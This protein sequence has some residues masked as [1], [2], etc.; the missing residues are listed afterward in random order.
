[1]R[2]RK[3]ATAFGVI[4]WCAFAPAQP[5]PVDLMTAMDHG[6]FVS[7]TLTDDPLST[8]GIFV[9][10]GIA[11]R[12]APDAVL[13]F[14]TDLLR[15]AR[16]WTG[17]FLKW[18]PA[19]HGLQEWP[20]PDGFSHHTTGPRPGWSRNKNFTDP[21]SRPYGPVPATV[22][23]Y[24]GLYLH[25]D[26]VVFSY[27]IGA[28]QVLDAPG[29]E[30]LENR[31]V[32]TRTFNVDASVESLSLL[33]SD[34]PDGPAST[35]ETRRQTPANGQAVIRSGEATRRIGFRGLP[36][37]A[38]WRREH[39]QLILDLPP[40]KEPLRFEVALGPI[41]NGN[42]DYLTAYLA[43]TG[44]VADLAP[45]RQPGPPRW[46]EI[47]TQAV[48]GQDNASFAVD[49]LTLPEDNPWRSYL[50]PSGLDFLP[51]GRA[52][53]ASLSG[54]V[55][56]VDGIGETLGTLRWKR[57]ATGLNQPL[58]VR[59]V[60][61]KIY[62]TGRDQITRL[63]DSNGDGTADYYENFNNDVMAAT[64][65]HAFTLNLETDSK[66]NFYFAKATPWPPV[67]K[68]VKAEITPHHG[69]LFRLSPDG[70]K[71][72]VVADGLRNPNGMTIGPG[73][74]IVYSDNEGNWV[75]TSKVHRIRL[76]AFHGFIPSSHS[77]PAPRDFEKP[78]AWIPHFVDNSPAQPIFIA[79]P[80]WPEELQGQLLLA[81][82]G[83]G[84]LSLLLKEEIEGQ[85]QGAQLTLP[86]NFMSG[87]VRGRFHRDGHL[88]L[89]GLTSWQSLGHGGKWG[90]VHRVRW[91]GKPLH[92][93]V[94]VATKADG[95]ELR[96][97]EPLDRSSAGNV[98]NFTLTQ[99]TYPWTSRYGTAGKVYSVK[100]PG[101]T[102]GDPVN[103]GAV[104][105]SEDGRSV[106]LTLPELQQDLA[107]ATVPPA[108]SLPDLIEAPL[109]LVIAIDYRL[110]SADGT[111]LKQ[112]LHQTIHRLPGVPLTPVHA[113]MPEAEARAAGS[114]H[115]HTAAAH[116]EALPLAPESPVAIGDRRV[117][118]LRSTGVHLSYDVTEIRAKAGERLVL[119][120]INQS[121]MAHNLV[122]V[123]SAED[124]NPVGLA[125]VSPQAKEFIPPDNM[126]RIVAHTKLAAPGDTV[127]LELTVPAT[128][129][130]YPYICTVSGHFSLM[131]GQL[132][133]T[134]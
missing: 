120:Y 8:S 29:F 1:M 129:G 84:T 116:T 130:V 26:R 107:H 22:G 42:G 99:W 28:V 57:F 77:D 111:E 113:K 122:V 94:A 31:P 131:Q 3:L 7:S 18:S 103:V 48:V 35:F 134:K 81:S 51:D 133:V 56:L 127:W 9:Y 96:F 63:H 53:V 78:I 33:V 85:W 75:P 40:L 110:K 52:V 126:H 15:V 112:L 47:E 93:P 4:A 61:G 54:D 44:E 50:R 74:E 59:V 20:T 13:V 70:S 97:R 5:A 102:G 90:S 30:R 62:I 86:L 21:R 55:W 87:L 73:D 27:R 67:P 76:G 34:V 79:S 72:E 88:Y 92:L 114:A 65:F 123:R 125:A 10:K 71:L 95:I 2:N 82:Y 80:R 24:Q 118:E 17:G 108:S 6:P 66:G 46:R 101:A 11:V 128:P 100:R 117:V 58:G 43:R 36:P 98:Q 64:N 16:G 132:V 106:F 14:D 60:D 23:R 49:E 32:F 105:V 19:R 37:D 39:R 69:A 109:G 25:G 45:L 41:E 121:E 68:G 38:R 12:V 83:R 124:I 115:G 89:A 104:R 91:T 119:R